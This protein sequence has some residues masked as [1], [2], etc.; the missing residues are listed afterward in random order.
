[1]AKYRNKPVEIEA[2]EWTGSK[3]C[4]DKIK[5]FYPLI[6]DGGA[7]WHP[8]ASGTNDDCNT[9]S[10]PLF[11]R[12]GNEVA[13]INIGDYLIKD[14]YGVSYPCKSEIFEKTYEKIE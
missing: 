7:V 12:N 10:W 8:N 5:E 14:E 13:S 11:V 9:S 6:I 4:F 3:N 1:M 2:I